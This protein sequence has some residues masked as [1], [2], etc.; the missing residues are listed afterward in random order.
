M[1][2]LIGDHDDVVSRADGADLLAS[3]GTVFKTLPQ[4]SLQDITAVV[5]DAKTPGAAARVE[6]IREALLGQV[7]DP[8]L[9]D[10][11][12]PT[13][14]R[15]VTQVIYLVHGIRDY[16]DWT[17]RLRE[18]LQKRLME[19]GAGD[20]CRVA[21]LKYGYFAMVP[22]ILYRDRQRNVRLFM[23]EYTENLTRFPGAAEAVDF[24]GHSN[25]TYVLASTLV[26]YATPRV[27][28]VLFAGSVV[29][30]HYPWERLVDAGRVERVVNIAATSDWVVAIFPKL[31]EQIAD[32]L[33]VRPVEGWLDIG[34]AGFRGFNAAG[35]AGGH[36]QN[37]KY[38]TGRHGAGVDTL[39]PAKR[40]ALAQF[41]LNGDVDSV[42]ATFKTADSPALWCDQLSNF[43]YFGWILAIATAVLVGW[44]G[45]GGL[46][47]AF[48]WGYLGKSTA[49]AVYF[50]LVVALLHSG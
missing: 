36:I 46:A 34:A 17:D 35:E 23:D 27:R 11:S 6:V 3:R 25:G 29:P 7:S 44:V 28:R 13:E 2:Q 5:T 12:L 38:T 1:I 18:E 49:L 20:T 31:F 40:D 24:A 14:D 42:R 47:W 16:G 8:D 10:P 9:T 32:W 45:I 39:V 26:R 21:N 43:S 30:K 50:V 4:T 48:S 33:N 19:Q 22:F 15:D 41:L 37:I